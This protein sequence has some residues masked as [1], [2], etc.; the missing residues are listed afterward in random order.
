MS[1]L[2]S[3]ATMALSSALLLLS[4]VLLGLCDAPPAR[5]QQH[6]PDRE[7]A[8]PPPD[9]IV[10]EWWTEGNEGRIR[11]VRSADATYSGILVGGKDPG[12]DVNNK[13]PALR[14][15]PLLGTVLVWHLRPDDGEYVDGYVYNPR[16]GETY[17]MKAELTG[18]TTLKVRGY[19]GISLLGQS[20]TWTRAN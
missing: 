15:R 5:A 13:D 14:S 19:L 12:P 11:F 2:A 6:V 1:K 4:A 18:K 8:T 17:R 9:A 3:T 20:Q 16:N 10:G 7:A